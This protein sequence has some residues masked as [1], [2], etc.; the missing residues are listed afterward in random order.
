M[1]T[2]RHGKVIEL[3][4]FEGPRASASKLALARY[5]GR[6]TE[7]ATARAVTGRPV[8]TP[9]PCRRRPGGHP[10][11]GTLH[12]IRPDVPPEI[13]WWCERCEDRGVIR[14]WQ[15]TGWNLVPPPRFQADEVTV[16]LALPVYRV[17]EDLMLDDAGAERLVA[18]ARLDAEGR[19]RIG[20]PVAD[21]AALVQA[22]EREHAT[23]RR[24]TR[25]RRLE[26]AIRAVSRGGAPTVG[27]RAG[28]GRSS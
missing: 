8:A 22:L 10:C 13:R 15:A 14:S 24:P 23:E 20:G 1:R 7:A 9:I 3:V 11:G 26:T 16:E 21:T 18:G 5:Y 28:R 2:G 25:R 17:L 6:I 12:V 4:D 27:G 19:V